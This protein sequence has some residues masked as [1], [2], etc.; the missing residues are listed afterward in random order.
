MV[1]VQ[2]Q[3]QADRAEQ[4]RRYMALAEQQIAGVLINEKLLAHMA[5]GV[6]GPQTMTFLVQLYEPTVANLNRAAK[7]RGAIEAAIHDG[8]VRV[9]SVRGVLHVEIPSPWPVMVPGPILRGRGLDIPLGLTGLNEPLGVDLLRDPHLLCVG[10]TRRGKT[11]AMRLIA[12]Q[13]ARQNSAGSV[14]MIAMTFKPGDWQAFGNL[15]QTMAII[16]NPTEAAACLTWLRDASLRRAGR[17]QVAPHYLV[18]VDDLLNLL[19]M[20]DVANVLME[21]ASIGGGVGIH[22]IIGTQRLGEK[23]AGS[24]AVTGNIPNRLVFGTADAQDAA[25]FSGRGKSGAEV[26][27]KHKGDALLVTDGGSQRLAVAY[28]GDADLT[29]LRQNPNEARPWLTAA[30]PTADTPVYTGVNRPSAGVNAAN[31]PPPLAPVYTG[32]NT[33]GETAPTPDPT[34]GQPAA[35]RSGGPTFDDLR[36]LADAWLASGGQ[37]NETFRLAGIT[38]SSATRPWLDKALRAIGGSDQ[39]GGKSA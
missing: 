31:D 24:A 22:L 11:T 36:R 39:V 20:V 23:G 5:G 25:Q 18:F 10:P 30:A 15:F 29:T 2:G 37:V 13:A 12:Y 9:Y 8:P 26:L 34:N 16:T 38:K 3:E 21:T 28:V 6:Q 14:R 33:G 19:G 32:V 7:L 1:Y 27:G 17:T 35:R 4:I